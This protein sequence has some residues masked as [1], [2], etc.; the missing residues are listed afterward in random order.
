MRSSTTLPPTANSP[1]PVN[2]STDPPAD[3]ADIGSSPAPAMEPEVTTRLC[4]ECDRVMH[5]SRFRLRRKGYAARMNQCDDC[6]RVKERE[7]LRAKGAKAR[8]KQM[9]RDLGRL[10]RA[11]SRT[12]IEALFEEMLQSYGGWDGVILAWRA[13]HAAES[14]RNGFGAFRAVQAITRLG[15]ALEE[16]RRLER[17]RMPDPS[18]LS[19]EQLER[20]LVQQAA[21]VLTR[22]PELAKR[23]A[24]AGAKT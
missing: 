5:Y 18:E 23:V 7:R 16:Q 12:G 6:H 21:G 22:N 8:R 11:K 17:A 20:A 19:D 15:L 4:V 13:Y 1:P 14:E 24:A 3:D 2:P 10:S 9:A